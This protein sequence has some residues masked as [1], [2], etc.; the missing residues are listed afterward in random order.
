MGISL[1]YKAGGILAILVAAVL[2][3]YKVKSW[4]DDALLYKSCKQEVQQKEEEVNN[5]RGYIDSMNTEVAKQNQA[6]EDLKKYGEEREKKLRETEAE[7]VASK[8]VYDATIKA[9]KDSPP[10]QD[11]EGAITWLIVNGPRGWQ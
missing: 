4:R 9:L 5:L 8:K 10:P 3:G 1:A 2:F 6:I 7:A 11:C